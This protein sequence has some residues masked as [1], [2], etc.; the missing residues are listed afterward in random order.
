MVLEA[1]L[2]RRLQIQLYYIDLMKVN[3]M[4]L[5]YSLDTYVL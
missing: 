3:L 2:Q 1:V 5:I 4:L